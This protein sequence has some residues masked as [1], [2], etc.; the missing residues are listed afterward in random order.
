DRARAQELISK[1]TPH[2]KEHYKII[3]M[4]KPKTTYEKLKEKEQSTG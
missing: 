4:N 3:K 1:A 2:K